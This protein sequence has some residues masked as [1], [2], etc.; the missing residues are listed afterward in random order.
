MPLFYLIMS[1]NKIISYFVAASIAAL[2]SIPFIYFAI[3]PQVNLW[4]WLVILS[5]LAAVYTIFLKTNNIVRLIAIGGFINCFYSSVP[6]M[7]FISF[8]SII[9]CC[10]FY[11]LCSKIKDWMPI[12]RVIQALIFINI[13]LGFMQFTGNDTVTNFGRE[14]EH[15][16]SVGQHMQMGSMAVILGGVGLILSPYN[17]I[18]VFVAA[19]LCKSAWA[20]FCGGVGLLIYFFNKNK[21]AAVTLFT[22][23]MIFF[24]IYGHINNKFSANLAQ[25]NGRMKIWKM[26]VARMNE[27]PLTGWGAGT[28]KYVFHALD[29]SKLNTR[30]WRQAH[31]CFLQAGFEFGYPGLLLSIFIP[32]FIA[33][34]L[35]K[36]GL[37]AE[38]AGLAM[39]CFDAM[40]HFPSRQIQIILP[41]IC[42]LAYCEIEIKRKG[43]HAIK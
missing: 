34:K 7:S 33:Y 9:G 28:F 1:T 31:N 23:I 22:V 18:F 16:G 38:L 40:V 2:A 37:M 39:I 14:I 41:I 15:Y 43:Y 3:K 26:T 24:G 25:G 5:G 29:G 8:M 32:L 27:K 17:L 12:F 19:I 30:P 13:L 20:V 36:L 42:F 10:Y 11:I 21:L 4:P 6:F 35:W